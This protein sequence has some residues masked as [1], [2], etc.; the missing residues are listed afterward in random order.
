[1]TVLDVGCGNG[2]MIGL[3]WKYMDIRIAGI[4]P[5]PFF[6]TAAQRAYPDGSF[7]KASAT[8][9]SGKSWNDTVDTWLRMTCGCLVSVSNR[10]DRH[11]CACRCAQQLC[12]RC[13]HEL[14]SR[15]SQRSRCVAFDQ[16]GS[17]EFFTSQACTLSGHKRRMTHARCGACSR[18][19]ALHSLVCRIGDRNTLFKPAA[20]EL[21][22]R[23]CVVKSNKLRMFPKGWQ[24]GR[25]PK[26]WL[27]VVGLCLSPLHVV[28][29]ALQGGAARLAA[30]CQI[31]AVWRACVQ[32][33]LLAQVSHLPEQ[34]WSSLGP[35]G[36]M[37]SHKH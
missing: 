25:E 34:G 13:N 11:A 7:C 24:F 2:Y 37:K 28:L 35:A 3:L 29:T 17:F 10:V 9:M 26:W 33:Q 5:L 19:V 16:R 4:D 30:G 20:A 23:I 21:Q 6:V 12:R 15:S 1:M 27:E 18:M 8:D 36:R 14:S 31:L 22:F 32:R